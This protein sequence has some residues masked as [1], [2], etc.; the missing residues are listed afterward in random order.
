MDWNQGLFIKETSTPPL[1]MNILEMDRTTH[2]DFEKFKPTWVVLKIWKIWFFTKFEGCMIKSKTNYSLSKWIS[3]KWG[4]KQKLPLKCCQCLK[5]LTYF[6]ERFR[7]FNIFNVGSVAQRA[8]KLLA[9]K[10]GGLNKKLNHT[11]TA[12]VV[13]RR[14]SLNHT[15]SLTD[16]NLAALWPSDPILIV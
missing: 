1:D 10:F 12:R 4:Q 2:T 7:L 15:Q 13:R 11:S 9:V 5:I 3:W 6:E 16:G 14:L 8:A